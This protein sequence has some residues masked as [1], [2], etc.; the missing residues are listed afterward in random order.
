MNAK[1]NTQLNA[2]AATIAINTI[3]AL[4][5][6]GLFSGNSAE[7]NTQVAKVETI[8]VVAKRA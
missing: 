8:T 3:L 7:Q 1:L 6:A 5:V 4:S 2:V